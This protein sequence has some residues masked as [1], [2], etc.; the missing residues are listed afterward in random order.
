MREHLLQLRTVINEV[1]RERVPYNYEI[2]VKLERSIFGTASRLA[3]DELQHELVGFSHASRVALAT[4][5][6]EG[7]RERQVQSLLFRA[8]EL[9]A[10]LVA[11]TSGSS[12]LE[13]ELHDSLAPMHK[14]VGMAFVHR[15]DA[16][17]RM[18]SELSSLS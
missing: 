12:Y 9:K 2:R 15:L 10:V 8:F 14:D 6:V 4:L 13:G 18:V 11:I 16:Y 1:R 5:P 3:R 7:R 17:E